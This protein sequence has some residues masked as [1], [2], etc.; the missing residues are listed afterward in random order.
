[1]K[2]LL[3]ILAIVASPF[4][5][6]AQTTTNLIFRVQQQNVV[7]GVS[8]NI[9]DTANFTWDH[10][11]K[12]D[13]LKIDGFLFGAT[14]SPLAFVNWIKQDI[15]DRAKAYSDVKLARD[16]AALAAKLTELLTKQTDLLSNADLNNLATIAAK[17]P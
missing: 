3:T 15:S 17:L 5:A 6:Q 2:K 9:V 7:A 8:T 12:K 14:G 11:T 16:N 10:A 13:A 1:M 4:V